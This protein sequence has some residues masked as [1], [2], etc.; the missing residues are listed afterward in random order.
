MD[1]LWRHVFQ[2]FTTRER[3]RYE[4]V[5]TKWMKLLRE[6]WKQLDTVDT[7]RLC[8]SEPIERWSDCVQAVL[9]RCSSHIKWFSFGR[10]HL[11]T[12]CLNT[13]KPLPSEVLVLLAEKA[14]SLRSFRVEEQ[15]FCLERCTV[16]CSDPNFI[17]SCFL[18][19]LD[20]C[21]TLEEF[22]ITLVILARMPWKDDEKEW[23][24]SKSETKS[25]DAHEETAAVLDSSN[26]SLCI[27][28]N[29]MEHMPS[30]VSILCLAT[31]EAVRIKNAN[32]V[33][34]LKKLRL[35][36]AQ[37]SFMSLKPLRDLVNNAPNLLYLDLSNSPFIGDFSPIGKLSQLRCLL[38]NGNCIYLEDGQLSAIIEGCELLEVLSLE[39]CSKLSN[40]GLKIISRCTILKELHLA[41]VTGVTDDTLTSIT[42]NIPLLKVLDISYC[43]SLTSKGLESLAMLQNL[44][45]LC[46]NGIHDFDDRLVNM[47]RLGRPHCIIEALHCR[48]S[49]SMDELFRMQV[50]F[51]QSIVEPESIRSTYQLSRYQYI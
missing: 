25:L 42:F 29:F 6:Y 10:G 45:H 37:Y 7:D 2:Y 4:R 40:E 31:G 13:K 50:A 24:A 20:N 19:L 30:T 5:S 28:D 14:P 48:Y 1:D 36:D 39:R 41:G 27:D 3:I 35:F 49:M 34:K 11:K 12:D 9:V 32:F 22:V 46:V 21:L 16:D 17:T 23:H 33:P 18:S 44:N 26:G 43:K 38:L 47:I 8:N 51:F 15:V